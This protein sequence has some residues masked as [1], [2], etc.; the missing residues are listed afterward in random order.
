VSFL[1]GIDVGTSSTK[2]LLVAE[3]GRPVGSAS[4]EYKLHS[5]RPGWTE[6]DPADWWKAVVRTVGG[7]L[8]KHKVKP[9]AVR[10]IGLSGQMH[11]SVFLDSAG[12]VLRRALLWND[13][14]TAEECA[15]I[16]SRAGGRAALIDLVA[17][18]ALTGFTAPK[19]LW[20]R[21]HEPQHYEKVAR[22]LLP[23]DYIRFRLTGE[24]ATEVSDASGTLL[25]DVRARNWCRPLLDKLEIPAGWLP[26]VFESPELSG[27]LTAAAAKALGLAPGVPVVGGGGDQAAGAVGA[28]I[29]RSGCVSCSVGTSGVVFAHSDAVQID[30]AGRVHTFCHAVP[31]K[32]H[33]MG[34]MLSAGGSLQWFRN[35]LADAERAAAAKAG[36]DVYELLADKL[37]ASAPAGC[38]GLMFLPYLTG[39]RTPHADP[40]ARAAWIGM[41]P[42]TDK[43]HLVRALLEGVTFGLRDSLQIIRGMNIPVGEIRALSGG[44][45]SP[46]WR[47]LMADVFG[48][49]VVGNRIE[50]GAAYGAALLAG[51]GTGVWKSVE[52][53]CD[54]CVRTTRPVKPEAAS[55]AVY[56]RAYPH[57][58]QLYRSLKGDFAR[59]AGLGAG[60]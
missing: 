19:V 33:V 54:T 44:A 27:R 52:E 4:A 13:Q 58:Q 20:L 50:E 38:E 3:N 22:L 43:A 5:P 11:G 1:L 56:D 40:H 6:Q 2:S 60:V 57:W 31:G 59:I 39:E 8:G 30:P 34:V 12:N 7:L 18:P 32:W 46:F 35:T 10:G 28:G 41:T 53:A 29:V 37:A 15:E 36:K 25:L 9:A 17:N 16:E 51:V 48:A 47:R 21:R 55:T 49:P 26:R 23:K 24:F 45:R 42:R 14:R